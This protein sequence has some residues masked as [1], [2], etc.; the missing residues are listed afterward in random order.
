MK[1][2]AAIVCMLLSACAST[3]QPPASQLPADKAQNPK[4]PPTV[5]LIKIQ[6][7]STIRMENDPHLLVAGLAML[8]V[9][10]IRTAQ[11]GLLEAP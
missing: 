5:A 6:N 1:K 3:S 7:P 10:K 2:Y 8:G 4:A 9:S 11:I